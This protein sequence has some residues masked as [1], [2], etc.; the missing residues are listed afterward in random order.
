MKFDSRMRDRILHGDAFIELRK[1]PDASIH[2]CVTSPPYWGLRDYDVEGQIGLEPT[3]ELYVQHLVEI[4]REVR[5]VLRND[6]TLWLNLGDSYAGGI[7]GTNSQKASTLGGGKDT[8]REAFKRPDKLAAGLKPKDLVGIP[9][10]VAFALQA[11]DWWLRSDIIWAKSNPMP[12]SCTDRPTSSH[13]HIFLLTKSGATTYWTHRDLSGVRSQ[14]KS[15]YRW[16]DRAN[17]NAETTDKPSNWRTE[18]LADGETK[19]WQRVNLW[20][21]HDYFYDQ[22]A[23]REPFNYPGRTYNPDVSNHKTAKLKEQGNRCTSGLHDGRTQYGD[24]QRG[25]NK[26]DVWWVTTRSFPDAHFAV[27]PPEL[28]RPCILAGTSER[29]CCPECG[30]PWERVVERTGHVNKREP[31][32]QPGNTPTKVDSTGWAPTTRATKHW[33]PTCSCDAGEPIPCIVLDPF[34]G[35]G[36]TGLVAKQEGRHYLGIELDPEWAEKAQERIEREC[37]MERLV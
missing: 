5:R 31:A 18:L 22:D 17:D 6:G 14:P 21:G 25:R 16:F 28:I 2:C 24:P 12:E 30:A 20:R 32:H 8:Q 4:F 26:R 19:R 15:D 13:E 27:Y 1:L 10:R 33:R 23:I 34:M 37:P 3:P 7:T 9:W 11:D 36:T 35:A 29:G